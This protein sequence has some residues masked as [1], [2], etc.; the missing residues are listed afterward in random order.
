MMEPPQSDRIT[1]LHDILNGLI[2]AKG[3]AG[4][5]IEERPDQADAARKLIDEIE[6]VWNEFFA[7]VRGSR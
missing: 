5:F 7:T 6:R 1:R 4:K 3:H 2:L